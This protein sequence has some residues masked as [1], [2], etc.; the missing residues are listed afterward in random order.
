MVQNETFP[1]PVG[2]KEP[3]R[4]NPKST[5]SRERIPSK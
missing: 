5:L 2:P 3:F 4:T 1:V